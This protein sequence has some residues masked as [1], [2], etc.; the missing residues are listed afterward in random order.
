MEVPCISLL[1]GGHLVEVQAVRSVA[2]CSIT[3]RRSRR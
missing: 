1:P 3:N 2:L